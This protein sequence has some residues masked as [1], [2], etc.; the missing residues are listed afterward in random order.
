[1]EK[2]FNDAII[3]NKNIKVSYSKKGELLRFFYPNI[4][5]R[6]FINFFDVGLKINDSNIIYLHK[7]VNNSYK[8][9]YTE[10]TNIL[11]TEI[12][13]TYFKLKI[14]QTDFVC[15]KEN[16]LVKKY[17][18]INQNNIKLDL[19]FLI[20]SG[21]LSNQN[22]QVS[23]FVKSNNLFQYMHD[24]I[25]CVFSQNDIESYQINDTI[26]NIR[27]GD[28]KDKD[29]IGMSDE[30]SLKYNVGKLK[31]GEEKEIEI[32]IY[33]QEN[34]SKNSN[35][36]EVTAKIEKYKKINFKAK[37]EETKKYWKEY[38]KEH[39]II[40][41]NK[42]TYPTLNKIEKIYK[43]T[44]LLYPLLI[45]HQTGGVSAAI[46]IDENI[47][48]C[49]RYNYC[50]PRDAIFI[51]KAMDFLNM[52][53][54]TEKFYN[55]FCKN[56]QNKNGMWE[57]RFYTDGRLAPSWG[58]QIDETASVI[59]GLYQ[60]YKTTKNIKFLKDNL[61]MCEKAIHFLNIYLEDVL[62]NEN[63]IHISYDLWEMNEGIHFYSMTSIFA[64]FTSM[65][66]IYEALSEE[67]QS[68]KNRLKQENILKQKDLLG[69]QLFKIKKFITDNF[70]DENKKSFVRNLEDKKIDISILASIEPFKM[71]S[72]K[73][74][75]IKNTVEKI[76]LT[77]R[78]YTGG[79]QRFEQDHYMGGN[80]WVIATLWMA[81][82][83]I[84]N[85]EYKK[86]LECFDF[87][88]KTSQEHGFLAE[89]IDNKTLNSGWIIGLGWSHA[90]YI[91]VLEKLV[92]L[93]LI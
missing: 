4:D 64:A 33:I 65:I 20:H 22:N 1:M 8:Q 12:I 26:Q 3:G 42:K 16:I 75:K 58:Y 54:E 18:F 19:D 47:T 27:S 76:N 74:K 81:L 25:F 68:I 51:T 89:Q 62:K 10:D 6:Q 40:K 7:D 63:K 79:Y 49:G 32:L 71:F 17:K 45:N 52:G 85:E 35:L 55:I 56:T 82:Y 80:P 37:E 72:S 23:G 66:E 5:Y 13:N 46:E 60:H 39:D 48:K 24:Y 15:I 93:K 44:I 57:Q 2:Y 88:V 43:R 84:E 34:N 41:F 36:E 87:V 31:P 9:Y 50:W 90:M 59:Y 30:S 14:I 29:Y 92:K 38:I 67:T 53:T 69:K 11:N 77:L 61:K 83:Y 70:Y 73:E 86:A 91:I 21:L 78:T 28:I